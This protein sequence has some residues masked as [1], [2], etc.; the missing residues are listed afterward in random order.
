MI[1]VQSLF[2]YIQNICENELMFKR[3]LWLLIIL[4]G[5]IAIIFIKKWCWA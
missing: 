2:D 5:T 1:I 4:I 3:A